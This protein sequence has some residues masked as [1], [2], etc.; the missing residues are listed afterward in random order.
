MTRK[1][2]QI[3]LAIAAALA[4]L[5]LALFLTNLHLIQDPKRPEELEPLAAWL[6]EHP[7]DWLAASAITD[8]S[9][10]S[11]LPLQR[12][13]ALW[14]S[15]YALAHYLAPLRPNPAGGFVR[16]GLFHWYE[17]PPNDRQ[18]V[19]QAAAPMLR[20]PAIFA[21][22][23]RP[24]WELTRD[25]GYLRR[26]APKSIDALW[27]LRELALASGD[28]GE[29]R[30]LRAA[31]TALRMEIFR[32][33]RATA[34]IAEL[35]DLLPRTLSD[36]D[37][38]LVQGILEEIDRRP[39]DVQ[40][41]GG[42]MEEIVLFTI[43]RE[44]QPLS[45]LTPFLELPGKLSNPTRA[46]LAIALGNR[47]AATRMELVSGH[48]TT[49]DWIPYHLE[50]A[51]FEEKQGDPAM[52]AMYRTRAT[53]ADV[54]RDL[55]T[56]LCGRDELCTSVFREHTA[57]LEFKLSVAQSDEIPPYV[58]IYRDDVL[59]AEG[60]VDGEKTYTIPPGRTEVRLMN[61]FTRSG[62][63]RRVRVSSPLSSRA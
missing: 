26:S 32:A 18:T 14:R 40:H 61:R 22:L 4:L 34:T 63:P 30:E 23:H 42:R 48:T 41:M 52:A 28:F 19:L 8:R 2:R 51:A 11:E 50:R 16:A 24:L 6:A 9:L 59:V 56:N 15:S 53:V 47:A 37:D 7:A 49:A 25:L 33:R 1:A 27:L 29:Y 36:T 46:R 57:P 5:L 39:F 35:T 43:R 31:L 21:A 45:A 3:T 38:A 10:D 54:P 62:V 13:I 44:L 12:R 55:W 20:D 58:E 60:E 17:L